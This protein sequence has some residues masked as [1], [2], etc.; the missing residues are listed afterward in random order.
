MTHVLPTLDHDR[1]LLYL[2][3]AS[4][5][6]PD[7]PAE[8]ELVDDE[9]VPLARTDAIGAVTALPAGRAVAASI[10]AAARD[11]VVPVWAN[12]PIGIEQLVGLADRAG[13]RGGPGAVQL[14][15]PT[16]PGGAWS[17][18]ARRSLATAAAA[19]LRDLGVATVWLDPL[20]L[21]ASTD[22]PDSVEA[23]ARLRRPQPDGVVADTAFDARVTAAMARHR[24]PLPERGLV[25]FFTGLSGSGK[26]TI[27][28]VVADQLGAQRTVSLL[29]GDRI[30]RLLSSGLGFSRADRDMNV[31]RIGFVAAEIGRHGGVAVCAP[32]APYA[33]TRATVRSMVAEADATFVLVHV[34]T[35][36]AECERRDRKGLYAKA[37]AGVIPE[38]TG[39]SDPYEAPADADLVLDTTDR[40]VEDCADEVLALVRP[41]IG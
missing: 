29:D 15:V 14:L 22:D 30:R 8:E 32:I 18:A 36:L 19:S 26:S 10:R 38:F 24:R 2:A 9:A 41:L 3:D 4:A 13:R 31:T 35:P 5:L 17:S 27:A 39:I 6:P 1:L 21:P 11:D 25:L 20:P 40:S 37:R 12:A 7:L 28:G 34:A 23:L 33:S 16:R